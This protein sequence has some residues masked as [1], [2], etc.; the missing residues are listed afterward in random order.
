M[1]QSA[2]YCTQRG[3]FLSGVEGAAPERDI[4]GEIAKAFV[5]VMLAL[6]FV[7]SF[8][9]L[10][11]QL[12]DIG[13]G[14]Y[15]FSDAVLFELRMLAHFSNDAALTA[16]ETGHLVFATL[17][18]NDAAQAL[19]RIVDV[20][21]AEQQAQIDALKVKGETQRPADEDRAE[22][23]VRLRTAVDSTRIT[24]HALLTAAGWRRRPRPR[25]G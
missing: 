25:R 13:S 18:T 21:P 22:I 4:A 3:S 6:V 16:A 15:R 5:L 19:D 2:Q 9:D 8:L 11:K 7:F 17:H 23:A 20:F 24:Y 12:D 1:G 14:S 10:I